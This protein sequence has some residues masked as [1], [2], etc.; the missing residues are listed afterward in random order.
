MPINQLF[1]TIANNPG[2]QGALGGAA[3]G[4]LASML[5]HKK[6][7]KKIGKTAMQVGGA[8]AI[9]GVGYYAYKKWQSSKTQQNIPQQTNSAQ[10]NV[11]P[12]PTSLP[13]ARTEEIYKA[14]ESVTVSDSLALGMIK[15]MIAAAASDG[16]IDSHEM[17]TLLAAM[18]E[19]NLTHAENAELTKTLNNPPTLEDIASIPSNEEEASEIYS[20]ALS[21]ID[22]DTPAENMFLKRLARSLNLDPN[23]VSYLHET[24][25]L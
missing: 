23:L 6:S 21:A 11:A 15:S 4:A 10:Q 25:K 22:P 3:S 12:Q 14:Y 24:A 20:A 17:D 8:A 9:A 16:S 2:A 18:D 1:Q 19:A 7:R 13:P 5:V